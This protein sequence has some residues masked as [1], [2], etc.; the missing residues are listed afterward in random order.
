MIKGLVQ[1]VGFRPFIYNL[2][3][4]YDLKGEVGNRGD[5]VFI[6]LQAGKKIVNRFRDDIIQFA[7]VSSQIKSLKIK[8]IA[9]NSYTSFDIAISDQSFRIET[10]ISPDIAVCQHC[11]SDLKT[12]SHRL[13]YPFINC[14]N[15]GPRF[16]IIK[17]LPYD[18]DKTTMSE[19]AMCEICTSEYNDV[20]DRRFHAQPIACNFCGP[21]YIFENSEEKITDFNHILNRIVIFLESGKIVAL[22]GQG[23][24][25][26]ICDALNDET[27]RLLRN[28]KLRDSKPFAVMFRDLKTINKYCYLNEIE[29]QEITSWKRPIIILRQKKSLAPSVNSGLNTIGAILPYMPLHYLLFERL[30][31]NAIVLTSGNISEEPLIINDDIAKIKLL[32]IVD[33]FVSYNREIFNRTDDSV[34]QIV[35]NKVNLIR[36]SRG[37]VPNPFDLKNHAS[38]ILAVGAEQKNCFCI[39]MNKQA[40]LSQYIGDL[41]NQETF[42]F[43]KESIERYSKI[44]R[45]IPAFIVCDLHPDYLST[46]FGNELAKKYNI[47]LRS[48]QHHHAHIVSCMAEHKLDEQV[49]GVSLDG[50]GYGCD[51]NTWGGEFFITDIL[52]FTR[53]KHFD[54]VPMPGGDAVI[55]E[56]WRMAISYLYQYFGNELN[57]R[58]FSSFS[59]LNEKKVDLILE[60]LRKKINSPLTSSTGRLF[61]AVSALT[62]LCLISQFDS[63]A[64]MRLEGAALNGIHEKYPYTI[65]ETSISFAK[66]FES[67]IHDLSRKNIS[68]ISAKFHNSIAHIIM[69]ISMQIRKECGINKVVLSGGVFQNKFLVEKTIFLLNE[70]NFEVFCNHIVPSNDGGIALGQLLFASKTRE[71]CV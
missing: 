38:G 53:Y 3:S 26:L 4:Q 68:I 69:D 5:G 58:S 46:R 43:F 47:P 24:Y 59:E 45:F 9:V 50:T 2:A 35:S 21:E 67:I 15:C 60:M 23:G 65:G 25:Q 54:Y 62:G 8:K 40:I 34:M 32:N 55:E 70:L 71:I 28:R 44:F 39:G 64:P 51:S 13:K 33:A 66:T 27:V 63:E 12:Q 11:L 19:F 10:E 20:K 57:I 6:I 7:P 1:G 52:N 16:T 14:T 48:I 49:I 22:K 37:F 41:K 42:D 17:D 18:R 29:E 56:P 61:D 31:L 30:K 36:R